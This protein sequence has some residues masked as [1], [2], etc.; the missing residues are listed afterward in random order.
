MTRNGFVL[1]AALSLTAS[2]AACGGPAPPVRY[3]QIALPDG[4]GAGQI[5]Q[6]GEGAPILAIERISADAA[7][8][9]PRIVYR[10]SPYRLDYYNYHR[11]SSP[12]GLMVTD[13]LRIAYQ[14]SGLFRSVVSGYSSDADAILAGRVMAIEEVNETATT[15]HA[16][17]RLELLLRDARTGE[18]LWSQVVTEIEPLESREPEGTAQAVAAAMG[19][20]VAVTGPLIA[21]QMRADDGQD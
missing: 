19:R 18:L 6:A 12:P 21:E 9:D 5:G 20:I 11:W 2:L 8:D 7:Y 15:W 14:Q 13:Y 16:R 10:E 17:I 4:D 1:A 3:Y